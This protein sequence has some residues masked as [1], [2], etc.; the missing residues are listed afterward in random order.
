M[1][2]WMTAIRDDA[3]PDED[4]QQP[5][6]MG[7]AAWKQ[8]HWHRRHVIQLASQLS[9]GTQDALAVLRLAT[10]L[11]TGFLSGR[12]GILRRSI[13]KACWRAFCWRIA[14]ASALMS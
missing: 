4:K 10:E 14:N 8:E 7:G 5:P 3:D 2:R 6:E 1:A 11:V 9:E 12:G 13:F